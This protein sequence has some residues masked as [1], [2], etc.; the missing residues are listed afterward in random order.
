[1][2]YDQS[3]VRSLEATLLK[4]SAQYDEY[5]KLFDEEEACVTTFDGEKLGQ[6]SRKKDTLNHA[7]AVTQ[8]KLCEIKERFPKHETEKLANLV[9]TYL[10]EPD[11]TRIAK[12]SLQLKKKIDTFR[13]RAAELNQIIGFGLNVIHGSLSIL[14]SGTQQ[15]VTAYSPQGLLRES[16]GAAGASRS[17]G[18]LRQA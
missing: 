11:A 14:W 16:F 12:L 1:M 3:F 18:I 15:R 5:L 6:L 9:Q 8:A 13:L 7:L 10:R 17:S 4:L 2:L